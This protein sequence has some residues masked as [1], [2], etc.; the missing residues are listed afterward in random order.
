MVEKLGRSVFLDYLNTFWDKKDVK[1]PSKSSF[2]ELSRLIISCF[3]RI[4]SFNDRENGL[5]LIETWNHFY[6]EQISNDG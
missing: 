5:K 4:L 2:N 6:Y 3:D 1:L